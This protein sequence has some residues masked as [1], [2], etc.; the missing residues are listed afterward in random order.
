MFQTPKSRDHEAIGL[1][2]ERGREKRVPLG[3]SRQLLRERNQFAAG[4]R[5]TTA[6]LWGHSTM[7]AWTGPIFNLNGKHYDYVAAVSTRGHR[8]HGPDEAGYY[9]RTTLVA[10]VESISWQQQNRHPSLQRA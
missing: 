1:A 4:K 7:I 5:L 8:G 10:G 9:V 2:G 6:N 3:I